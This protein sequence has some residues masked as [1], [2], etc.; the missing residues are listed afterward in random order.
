MDV[1]PG[2]DEVIIYVHLQTNFNKMKTEEIRRFFM[3]FELA[4]SEI[5]G[6]ECWST[7]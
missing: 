3:R 1:I 2:L 6:V 4:A 7:R 5:E